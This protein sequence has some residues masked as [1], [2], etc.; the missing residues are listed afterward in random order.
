MGREDARALVRETDRDRDNEHDLDDDSDGDLD[1]DYSPEAAL[2]KPTDNIS[3]GLRGRRSPLPGAQPAELP[4]EAVMPVYV[5]I[6]RIRRLVMAAVDEPYTLDQLRAPRMN[7]QLVRPLV[8]RLYNPDDL[9]TVYCLLANRVQFLRSQEETLQQTVNIARA[10]VCELV[11]TRILR[12]FH[13][14]NPG[15]PGLLLLANILVSGFDAFDAA[16]E[17]VKRQSRAQKWHAQERGGHE[18]KLIALELAILSESKILIGSIACQRVVDAVH[19]GQV[20]YTPLSLVDILPDHYKHHPVSLYEPRRAAILNHRRLIVPQL[21]N[22]IELVHFAILLALYVLTMTYCNRSEGGTRSMGIYEITFSIF[23]GGWVLEQFAAIIEHGW[24]VHAQNLWSFLDITFIFIYGLYGVIR[25]I[26]LLI[27]VDVNYALPILC[28]AAPI[29]L[30]RIAFNMMPDNIV[31]IA[32]HAMMRDFTR[33]TFIAIWCFT[34]FLL[35]LLWLMRTAFTSDAAWDAT[36]G[37]SWATIGKWLLWIWFGLDGT[38]IERTAEFH[39][40][41]GPALAVT[42][43]FL[44]NTLFLTILVA[45]LTN[46]F[47]KIMNN[48]ATEVQFRRAV[49]TFQ[50][51]KSDSIFAYPPPFNMIAL[52]FML[53]L[54]LSLG[55]AT[56]HNI[57]V[58]VIRTVNAP[59]LLLIALYERRRVWTRGMPT[60]RGRGWTHFGLSPYG[61][62]QLVFAEPP[63]EV[64]D[65]LEKLD[66]LDM[67]AHI[68]ISGGRKSRDLDAESTGSFVRRRKQSDGSVRSTRVY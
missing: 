65:Q 26:E 60:V 36:A 64:L 62:I 27:G 23:T 63:P 61:D 44:G 15:R 29:L 42:F 25:V 43:A 3:L 40:Y 19:R 55:P 31:F 46:T 32:L 24:E 49:L 48:A 9:S 54:R 41:L 67:T 14:D 5:T 7:I 8:D 1:L 35:G 30:T 38:G 57:N 45:I 68:D 52:L 47:S 12:R 6:H 34:G 21:R 4:E 56:F 51:V 66:H 13:E 2:Y 53:P 59:V 50:A 18:R 37:P 16:P 58:A 10:I 22:L 28:T 20:V 33:L 39:T 17:A 11:A